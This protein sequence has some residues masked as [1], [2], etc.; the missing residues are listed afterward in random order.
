MPI[1]SSNS[2]FLH[3]KLKEVWAK[4]IIL[5]KLI[6]FH[7]LASTVDKRIFLDAASTKVYFEN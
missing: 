7:Y 1:Q 3:N 2:F 4:N 5:K 6:L